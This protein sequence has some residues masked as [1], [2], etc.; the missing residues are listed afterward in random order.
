MHSGDCY[1]AALTG[2]DGMVTTRVSSDNFSRH[3]LARLNHMHCPC[4]HDLQSLGVFIS[5]TLDVPT[6][7]F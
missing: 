3:E 4:T 6:K 5:S 7:K 1:A 2:M